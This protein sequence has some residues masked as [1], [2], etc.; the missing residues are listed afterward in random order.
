M[1][2]ERAHVQWFESEMFPDTAKVWP[3]FMGENAA[4]NN[5]DPTPAGLE[6]SGREIQCLLV[7]PI[8]NYYRCATK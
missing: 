7:L 2:L 1:N 5:G 3:R 4:E 6:Y 8:H